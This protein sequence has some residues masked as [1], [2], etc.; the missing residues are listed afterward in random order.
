MAAKSTSLTPK[1]RFPEFGE[2]PGWEVKKAGDVFANRLEEG[3]EGLPIYSVTMNEGMVKRDS[4]DRDFYDIED[5]QGN[6]QAFRNDIT[7]NMMRMWQGALGVAPEDCMVSPAYVVLAPKEDVCSDFY[8]YLF[9]LPEYLRVLTAHS[10][11]LTKDRLRLYYKD[12]AHIPLPLPFYAE[13]RKIAACL[14]SLDGLIAAEGRK[15]AALR[16][17]K[18]GLMQQL[19]PREGESRPRLRFP[20]FRDAGEWQGKRLDEI[21]DFQSGGTPSK[22][23]PA[24]WN[25]SIPWVSAKDMKRMVLDDT[26]DHISDAAVEDGAKVVPAG[27][28]LMLTRGMT[29]LKDVPICLVARPTALNQDVRALRPSNGFDGRFLAYMLVGSKQRIRAM[30][31]IAGHGTGR[32]NTDRL[33]ALDLLFPS[34]AEQQRIAACLGALDALIAAASRK[35]DALRAHKKGLM[36]QLFPAAGVAEQLSMHPATDSSDSPPATLNVAEALKQDRPAI[37]PTRKPYKVGFARQLL[38]AEILQHC[39]QHPT[40]GRVKLQKLIHLCEY[41]AELDDIHGSYA[42]AAAGPFDNKL[43]R[44][45]ASGLEKQKWFKQVRHEKHTSYQPMQ[46]SGQHAKYLQRWSEQLPRIHEVIQLFATAKTLSC[47]I[48]STLYAAWNDLL[49]EGRQPTDEEIIREASDPKRWHESKASIAQIKWPTAL[50]WM[51]QKG[52][53]PRGYGAHTTR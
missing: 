41:Y 3:K 25:G 1:L 17:H 4:L 6:K 2:T 43:M 42:R 49:I 16:A 37:V 8:G 44:G 5:A 52:L 32:L 50:K 21:A 20:E 28:V 18:K 35:L 19:F 38:A 30:V 7:Y 11:G 51:R 13:Q 36:Q 47:E 9:K 12:F 15:L 45:V 31:D 24:F 14:T 39:H 26:E 34:P 23:K 33:K 10:Q 46:L 48:A 53:V 29:L 40:M 22:S 27:T